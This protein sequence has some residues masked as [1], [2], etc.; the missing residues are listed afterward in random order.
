[1]QDARPLPTLFDIA[2]ATVDVQERQIHIQGKSYSCEP[3]VFDLLILFCQYPN[4][5]ITRDLLIE[6]VWLGRIVS[7]NAI[8]RAISQLRKFLANIDEKLDFV[9]TV[10]RLGYR[11]VIPIELVL[12]DSTPVDKKNKAASRQTFL[13]VTVTVAVVLLLA[14]LTTVVLLFNEPIA[15][16]GSE[17]I[18][19]STPKSI[20]SFKGR[21][22]QP[23]LSPDGNKLAFVYQTSQTSFSHLYLRDLSTKEQIALT[24]DQA[25]DRRPR[26]SPDGKSLLFVRYRTE[27]GQTSCHL[28][29]L[30]FKNT[31]VSEGTEKELFECEPSSDPVLDWSMDNDSFFYAERT[32]NA[33]PYSIYRYHLS[34]KSKHQ[35]S[36]PPTQN[37]LLGDYFVA[38]NNAGQLVILQYRENQQ[39]RI[40]IKDSTNGLVSHDI[41]VSGRIPQIAWA[42]YSPALYYSVGNELYYLDL[43]SQQST[44]AFHMGKYIDSFAVAANDQS[45]FISG[46]LRDT[47]IWTKD[48]KGQAYRL[49]DSSK[50]DMMP[51]WSNTRQALAFVSD[52]TGQY[53][54]WLRDSQKQERQLSKL[55]FKLESTQFSWS[56]DDK[57]LLFQHNGALYTLDVDSG[58]MAQLLDESAKAYAANWSGDGQSVIYGTNSSGDWQLRKYDIATK[59]NI[60][61][62]QNGG[63]SGLLHKNGKELFLTKFH[64][65]GL[66]QLDLSDGS[67]EFISQDVEKIN[68]RNWQ[69][70]DQGL[71]YYQRLGEVPG[72]YLHPWSGGKA[73]ILWPVPQG[74]I[75]QYSVSDNGK[76]LFYTHLNELQSDIY[77]LDVTQD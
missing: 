47:D 25:W 23:H 4:E 42:N 15:P 10:P 73:R 61:L 54:F 22:R 62:T 69:I 50:L 9:V 72:L 31:E 57:L 55:P 75:H 16:V 38:A 37:N 30:E 18:K 41:T 52:R 1:M 33:Q 70:I 27:T 17:P 46:H 77:R 68:W 56:A 39:T 20:T 8:N 32:S 65:D 59:N 24:Q 12:P 53:E 71:V 2:G 7:E 43:A 3:K 48:Q 35:L 58:E 67:E 13:N 60:Q 51:R 28:M 63:Y 29:L 49:I 64:Q 34:T 40:L 5:L 74:F 19:L 21:S 14:S 26:W 11:F 44:S 76:R 45:L 66:W 6:K 36:L